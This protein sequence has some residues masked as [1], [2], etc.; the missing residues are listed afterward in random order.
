MRS[1]RVSSEDCRTPFRGQAVKQSA[2]MRSAVEFFATAQSGCERSPE[3]VNR[4]TVISFSGFPGFLD[5]SSS[6]KVRNFPAS[7]S[8]S[9]LSAHQMGVGRCSEVSRSTWQERKTNRF[10]RQMVG[11][12]FAL[13]PPSSSISLPSSRSPPLKTEVDKEQGHQPGD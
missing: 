11:V 2:K 12:P 7:F 6:E 8:S 10:P 4:V 1:C 3:S 5:F 13:E 9:E